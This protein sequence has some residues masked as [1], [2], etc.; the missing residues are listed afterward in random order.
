MKHV[1]SIGLRDLSLTPEAFSRPAKRR[2]FFKRVMI[3]LHLARRRQA[4]MIIRNHRHL[5]AHDVLILPASPFLDINNES[6]QN[7]NADQTTIRT[8]ARADRA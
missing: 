1:S 7:A 3:A 6:T 5:L 2:S 8:N 4:R